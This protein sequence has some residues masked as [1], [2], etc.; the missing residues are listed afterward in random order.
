MPGEPAPEGA[1]EIV[2]RYFEADGARDREAVLSHFADDAVVVDESRDWRGKAA[3]R[4]WRHGPASKYEY[5]NTVT[6]IDRMGDDQWRASGRI[7]GNFP[8][9]TAELKWDFI[10]TEGLISRL[11]I[12]P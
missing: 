5:T 9:G 1:P 11:E 12:A 2:S 8:G 6:R 3:I 7:D 4:E 10:L